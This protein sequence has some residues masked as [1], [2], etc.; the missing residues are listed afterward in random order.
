MT[1][2]RVAR[3][4]HKFPFPQLCLSKRLHRYKRHA[5]LSWQSVS[6]RMAVQAW[7]HALHT[8][9]VFGGP[10]YAINIFPHATQ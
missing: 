8:M 9:N 5:L 10:Q 4:P 2:C 6:Q 7:E 1:T 3:E